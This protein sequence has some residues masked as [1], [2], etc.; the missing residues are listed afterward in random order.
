MSLFHTQTRISAKIKNTNAYGSLEWDGKSPGL[1]NLNAIPKH[2]TVKVGDTIITSGYARHFPPDLVIGEIV[3]SSLESGN[4]FYTIRVKLA[5]DLRKVKHVYAIKN[6]NWGE[7][8]K[9]EKES[10]Q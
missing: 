9:V 3:E 4:N 10:S 6:Q 7:L 8:N 1:M 2:D 5:N